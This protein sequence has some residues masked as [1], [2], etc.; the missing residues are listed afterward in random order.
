MA[1]SKTSWLFELDG[2]ASD[3]MALMSLA[4][5]CNCTVRPGPDAELWLGGAR[6]DGISTSEKGLEEARKTLGLL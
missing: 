5:A 4:S 1:A 2:E 6:F 3:L